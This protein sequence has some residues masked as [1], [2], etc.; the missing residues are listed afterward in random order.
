M[1]AY[2]S[3]FMVFK[4]DLFYRVVKNSIPAV[5]TESSSVGKCENVFSFSFK[6]EEEEM[7]VVGQLWV[8]SFD[9]CSDISVTSGAIIWRGY[10]I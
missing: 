7:V 6:E 5:H 1:S 8:W 2:S 3:T 9:T 4:R 10:Y